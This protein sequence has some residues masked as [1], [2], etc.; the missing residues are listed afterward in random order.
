MMPHSMSTFLPS[1]QWP[2]SLSQFVTWCLMWDPKNRPTSTQALNHE[3][4]SDA[5]DPLRPKSSNARILGRKQSDL[6]HR[7]TSTK[8]ESSTSTSKPSWFRKSLIGRDLAPVLPQHNATQTVTP[9]PAP[10]QAATVVN[11][12]TT[13]T[14]A[15]QKGQADK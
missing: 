5:I 3:Y 14:P 11:V 4:F 10:V 8:E 12:P 2:A 1:P 7:T 9:K 13:T 6:N 15:K